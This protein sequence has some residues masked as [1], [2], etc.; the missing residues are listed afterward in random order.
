[1]NQPTDKIAGKINGVPDQSQ[2]T[3]LG[4]QPPSRGLLVARVSRLLRP[5]HAHSAFSATV[6]LMVS[7]FLSRIIGLVR[8]KYIVWLFGSGMSADALT[9]PSCCPT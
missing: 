4:L 1:M 8:V 9:P 6:V 7:T 5:S 2:I 3:Q